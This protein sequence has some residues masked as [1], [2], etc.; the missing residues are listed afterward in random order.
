[1]LLDVPPKYWDT[2]KQLILQTNNNFR[3]RTNGKLMIFRCLN[4]LAFQGTLQGNRETYQPLHRLGLIVVYN[5]QTVKKVGY[6][7]MRHRNNREKKIKFQTP[8][9]KCLRCSTFLS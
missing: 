7:F 9:N 5:K 6:P 8:K 3:F 1:M 2:R 4:I